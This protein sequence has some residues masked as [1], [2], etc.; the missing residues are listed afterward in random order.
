MLPN[1]ERCQNFTKWPVAYS[2]ASEKLTAKQGPKQQS[3]CVD[4]VWGDCDSVGEASPEANKI[5]DYRLHKVFGK[6]EANT[7]TIGV[8]GWLNQ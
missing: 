5:D 2:S 1:Y 4:W 8:S 7:Q 6:K 3:I